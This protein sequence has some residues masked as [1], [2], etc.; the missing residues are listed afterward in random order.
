[1]KAAVGKPLL[2]RFACTAGD[3]EP[4]AIDR[5]V[6]AKFAGREPVR[7]LDFAGRSAESSLAGTPLT[8]GVKKADGAFK[9]FAK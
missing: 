4:G 8:V 9:L 1:M 5:L 2:P 6:D 7:L 3:E